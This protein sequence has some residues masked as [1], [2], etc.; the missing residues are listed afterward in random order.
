[1]QIVGL[2][3]DKKAIDKAVVGDKVAIKLEARTSEESG[4]LAGRH[5]LESDELYSLISR[6]SINALKSHFRD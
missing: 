6:E 4:I 2:E 5:F 3:R 1:M